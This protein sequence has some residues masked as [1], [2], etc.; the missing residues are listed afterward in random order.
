MN[1]KRTKESLLEE[2]AM[3][4]TRLNT[5]ESEDVRLRDVFSSLLSQNSHFREK[6][7]WEQVAFKIGELNNNSF[8][9]NLSEENQRMNKQID[10]LQSELNKVK[11][12]N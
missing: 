10:Y 9:K 6:L 3:L 1:K 4:H 5:A 8:T 12:K 2:N 11:A 7:S